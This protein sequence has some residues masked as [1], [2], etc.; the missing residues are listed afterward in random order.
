[1]RMPYTEDKR[2]D[3][4]RGFHGGGKSL[5]WDDKVTVSGS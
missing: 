5:M 2:F 3:W 1:M 4:Y